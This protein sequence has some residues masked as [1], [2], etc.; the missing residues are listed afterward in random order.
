MKL[1]KHYYFI[2]NTIMDINYIFLFIETQL[3][4]NLNI[5]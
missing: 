4:N 1:C 2:H 5:I 3:L